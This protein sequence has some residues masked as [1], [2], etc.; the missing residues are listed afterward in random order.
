MHARAF[1]KPARK[2]G[3]GQVRTNGHLCQIVCP[4]AAMAI[5]MVGI[6]ARPRMVI[7]EAPSVVA[8]YRFEE[9]TADMAAGG[10]ILDWLDSSPDGTPIGGP[11]YRADVA[12]PVISL[13]GQPNTLSLEFAGGQSVLFNAVFAFHG[14]SGDATLE[15]FIKAPD[16]PHHSIFWTRHDDED[17]NR[18][19]IAINN[20]GGLGLDYRAPSGPL[21]M[22]AGA[23]SLTVT[24][25]VWTHV[26]I[27]RDTVSAAP[28]HVY[29]FYRDGVLEGSVTDATPDLPTSTQWALSG[30]S[31]FRFVGLLDEI[32]LSNRALSPAE[33]LIGPRVRSCGSPDVSFD[34]VP[35]TTLPVGLKVQPTGIGSA[36]MEVQYVLDESGSV[37]ATDFQKEK[38][39]VHQMGNATGFSPFRR[40]GLTAYSTLSRLIQPL[41]G[42]KN[43]FL[44]QLQGIVQSGGSTCIGCGITTASDDL[45]ASGS[46]R[47]T[48]II[49]LITDGI[50]NQ[51]AA[52]PE[53]HLQD[54]ISTADARGHILYAIGVG[55]NGLLPQLQQIATPLEGVQT[56]YLTSWSQLPNLVNLILGPWVAIESGQ[57]ELTMPD[58]AQHL[59]QVSPDPLGAF[60]TPAW[61]IQPGTNVFQATIKTLCGDRTAMLTLTG[62][63]VPG[64]FNR[65]ADVDLDDFSELRNCASG[66][67]VPRQETPVCEEA[68]FD[69]DNDVD[70]DDFGVFQ[71]CFRGA[72]VPGDPHCAD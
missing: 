3:G 34:A 52:N 55:D 61:T 65:D 53:Q 28:S 49:L 70:V 19:N 20:G 36:G 29:N 45:L 71:R 13:T 44:N 48:Q 6:L 17:T 39:F 63:V 56:V 18:Y 1:G 37:S 4:S 26:A 59:L 42:V 72:N 60:A 32:R 58:G 31:A 25:G 68:D 5:V 21:H 35:N 22:N 69:G 15:F 40:A 16:Q 47:R 41:T 50:N 14:T 62:V 67:S 7:A 51:P 30:R 10:P 9:G 27:T 23:A 64:D 24:P 43:L 11:V 12:A 33:F 66:A 38:D 8:W 2:Q 46:P 57:V 54:A